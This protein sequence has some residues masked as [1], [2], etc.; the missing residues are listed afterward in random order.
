MAV[1]RKIEKRGS[2]ETAKR[3]MGYISGAFERA[4]AE[5][6]VQHNP[7]AGLIRALKP[8][9]RGAKQPAL[10][11]VPE[12]LALQKAVDVAAADPA[13]KLASRLL[14]LTVVRVGVLRAMTWDEI[15]G[16]D[17]DDPDAP[18]PTA[19]WRIPA[20][21][22]K[23]EVAEKGDAA[24]DHNVPLTDHA[25]A[26]LRAMRR[27]TGRCRFVF[28]GHRSTSSPM[29]DGAVSTLYRRLGYERRHVPH[30][31]RAAFSTIMNERAVRLDRDLDRLAID[32]MLAHV[33]NGM[34]AS[35]FA[36]NR[37]RY[38]DRRRELAPAWDDPITAG[39]EPPGSLLP[40]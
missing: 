10:T 27:L 12:L 22:M 35:E 37:A 15:H 34:S 16:I 30:G 39:L 17:W 5:H 6:L 28:P 9:P 23:L 14:A 26:V 38:E 32:L 2:I 19:I 8:T 29:S 18:C 13:T 40:R 31:W 20:T 1:L 3:V 24:Y 7:T 25:V 11:T 21:R 36:Y 4:K 33:P